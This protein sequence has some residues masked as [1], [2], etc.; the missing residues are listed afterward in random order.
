MK[1]MNRRIAAGLAAATLSLT[2]V[3]CS[4]AEDAATTATDTAGSALNEAGE[5]AESAL[6]GAESEAEGTDAEAT[7]TEAEGEGAAEAT[8]AAADGETTTIN[9]PAGDFEVPAAFA[10]AVEGKVAEW[11]DIVNIE[12]S[13]LGSVA[14][15]ANGDL[16]AWAKDSAGEIPVVG[17]IAETW[18]NEGGI[19]SD[20]GLPTGPEMTEGTGWIQEFANGTISWL[21]GANG[22]YE[23]TIN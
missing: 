22:E 4:E 1:K 6:N 7:G 12:N 21:Q 8:D 16:L 3:A 2:M 19:N 20:L 9:T 13:D 5:A 15:Y 10:S 17:K 11:G 14:E 23:A 18:K